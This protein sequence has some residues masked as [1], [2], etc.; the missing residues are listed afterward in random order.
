MLG[1]RLQRI[2]VNAL[3]KWKT[4]LQMVGLNS[5]YVWRDQAHLFGPKMGG[6]LSDIHASNS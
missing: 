4:A 3:G 2:A 5:M 1:L 6:E